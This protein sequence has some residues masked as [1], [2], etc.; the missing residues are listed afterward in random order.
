M[1]VNKNT[2][3]LKE[4]ATLFL[5]VLFMI[6]PFSFFSSDLPLYKM[7]KVNQIC[8]CAIQIANL[9]NYPLAWKFNHATQGWIDGDS[10]S[11]ILFKKKKLPPPPPPP[12][13][14]N[15]QRKLFF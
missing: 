9:S 11:P 5:E 8:I 2:C 13:K 14:K 3:C 6:Q 12:Q 7:P 1:P 15:W 4:Q 10:A